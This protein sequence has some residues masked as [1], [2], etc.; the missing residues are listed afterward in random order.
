[1]GGPSNFLVVEVT[2]VLCNT[3]NLGGRVF[4]FNKWSSKCYK[5]ISCWR[6]WTTTVILKLCTFMHVIA[7]I[8]NTCKSYS[9]SVISLLTASNS[10][11]RDAIYG[12]TFVSSVTPRSKLLLLCVYIEYIQIKDC[13]QW[14]QTLL[15]YL[16]HT[17]SNYTAQLIEVKTFS[18]ALEMKSSIDSNRGVS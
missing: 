2:M 4:W 8:D 13:K 12:H 16:K 1:M 14:S 5:Y 15:P 9:F 3:S 18:I 7:C 17:C 6:E 11:Q 10:C